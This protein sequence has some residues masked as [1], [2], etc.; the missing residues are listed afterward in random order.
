MPSSS[1]FVFYSGPPCFMCHVRYSRGL[2]KFEMQFNLT[3]TGRKHKWVV[4]QLQR[5]VRSWE[6]ESRNDINDRLNRWS[7][8]LMWRLFYKPV[9]KILSEWY[10][11]LFVWRWGSINFGFFSQCKH[12]LHVFM[13]PRGPKLWDL[14]HKCSDISIGIILFNSTATEELKPLNIHDSSAV[15][16]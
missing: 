14:P 7:N 12:N 3:L 6:L 13:V 16:E 10:L 4:D 5:V 1:K 8:S 11:P 9:F 2:I 15:E